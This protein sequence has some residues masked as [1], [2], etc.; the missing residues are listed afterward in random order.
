MRL[1]CGRGTHAACRSQY[2]MPMLG[3]MCVAGSPQSSQFLACSLHWHFGPEPTG[4]S[5]PPGRVFC[6]LLGSSVFISHWPAVAEPARS[7]RLDTEPETERTAGS[8]SNAAG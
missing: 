2:V 3:A 4:S 5:E 7:R 6:F 1:S 8:A